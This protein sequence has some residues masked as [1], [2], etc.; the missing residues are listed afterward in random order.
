MAVYTVSTNGE[1][2][3][4]LDA[5]S[6]TGG[7]TI[8]LKNAG[9]AYSLKAYQK[10]SLD[11]L[12]TIRSADT[13]NPAV[14]SGVRLDQSRNIAFENISVD[15]RG[16]D[17]PGWIKDFMVESSN[18]ISVSNSTFVSRADGT[19]MEWSGDVQ[20]GEDMGFVRDTTG[21]TFENNTVSNYMNGLAI[22]E[23]NDIKVSGNEF[24]KMQ[25][26][27]IRGGGM[28]D[29]VFE[30][31]WLH[32]W[33]GSAKRLNHDDMF[34]IWGTNMDQLSKNILI[35]G[36]IF[37]SGEGTATQTILIQNEHWES[38][39]D[40]YSNITVTDNVIYNGHAHGISIDDTTGVTVTH[41]T[42]LYNAQ[43]ATPT[44]KI[45]T[46]PS[47]RVFNPE[48]AE[49]SGNIAANILL[50][51]VN[52]TGNNVSVDYSSSANDNFVNHHFVNVYNGGK[53]DLR[54]L[55]LLSDSPWYGKYGAEVT[56][57]GGG[58]PGVTAIM[59]QMAVEGEY[60][61]FVLDAGLSRDEN[62]SLDPQTT[63]YTWN[64]A[65]GQTIDGRTIKVDLETIGQNEIE[66][67]VER[68]DGSRDS[69]VRSVL[70]ED[71]VI[72]DIDFND[73]ASTVGV[74]FSDYDE[75]NFVAGIE[76]QGFLLDGDS[77]VRFNKKSPEFYELDQFQIEFAFRKM[78][79]KDAGTLFSLHRSMSLSVDG[80]GTVKYSMKTD[81][82]AFKVTSGAH[83]VQDKD[84]HKVSV[85][86]NQAYEELS[87]WLDGEKLGETK[88]TGSTIP[89]ENW[90][91]MLGNLNFKGD[92]LVAVVDDFVFSKEAKSDFDIQQDHIKTLSLASADLGKTYDAVEIQASAPE[93]F[94]QIESPAPAQEALDVLDL[95]SVWETS[96][97]FVA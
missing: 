48:G 68:A 87:L 51:G 49:V 15:S 97:D 40:N 62:G 89:Y 41:N 63:R 86:Y 34:Q 28:Q 96:W 6:E 10:G 94:E 73:G 52:Q 13:D 22:V 8:L 4:A 88:A 39:A 84:W 16:V 95:S 37:D 24:T 12:T 46:A 19:L 71:P 91:P 2:R 25:G 76:G 50:D 70:V 45:S 38:E 81:D 31:N 92:S 5:A 36:N 83:S 18:N 69:I 23:S 74:S 82:G 54:D 61:A 26:D 9:D 32:D 42:V 33:Y 58:Q 64:F 77:E 30:N 93:E 72:R 44:D 57:G 11:G 90:G 59:Q 17:R 7:G 35:K 53:V 85:T 65:D 66:L 20:R 75:S 29:A 55:E 14:I 80:D 79:E 67:A 1:L 43:S 27:G 60:G 56:H 3:D 47:I 78:D 21:F